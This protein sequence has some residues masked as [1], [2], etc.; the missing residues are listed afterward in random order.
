MMH[1]DSRADHEMTRAWFFLSLSLSLSNR[2]VDIRWR[3]LK[4]YAAGL[5]DFENHFRIN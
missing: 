4:R 3:Y 5:A 2:I 1:I